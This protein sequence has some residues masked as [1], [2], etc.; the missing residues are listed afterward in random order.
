MERAVGDRGRGEQV[1]EETDQSVDEGQYEE[2]GTAI[3]VGPGWGRAG[4]V[5]SGAVEGDRVGATERGVESGVDDEGEG[6]GQEKDDGE[7]Q[8]M[9]GVGVDYTPGLR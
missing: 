7:G 2:S 1:N 4:L 8:E 6:E 3:R 9:A 5:E